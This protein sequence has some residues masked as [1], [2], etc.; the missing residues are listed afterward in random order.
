MNKI[1]IISA[2]LV[3]VVFLFFSNRSLNGIINYYIPMYLF[4]VIGLLIILSTLIPLK[5]INIAN[6]IKNK[7]VLLLFFILLIS[8]TLRIWYLG[9]ESLWV[10]EIW[11]AY[12]SLSAINEKSFLK[13]FEIYD[14]TKIVTLITYISGS[15][16]GFTSE[17]FLRLPFAL[18]G[19][20]SVFISY[21]LGK[22]FADNRVGMIYAWISCLSPVFIMQSRNIR[23]Y[24][25][26]Q[27]SVTLLLYLYLK[28]INT[29]NI[30]MLIA[31][32]FIAVISSFLVP[33]YFLIIIP[34]LFLHYLVLN[35]KALKV[36][37]KYKKTFAVFIFV[38]VSLIAYIFFKQ[39]SWILNE[40]FVHS[41]FYYFKNIFIYEFIFLSI[42][43]LGLIKG[44]KKTWFLYLTIFFTL[45]I[46]SFSPLQYP[47]YYFFLLP[48]LY[49]LSA[50]A[51]DNFYIKMKITHKYLGVFCMLLIAMLPI[52]NFSKFNVYNSNV[53]LD[54]KISLLK[55]PNN[56]EAIFKYFNY[57]F[58]EL[59]HDPLL[60]KPDYK[61]SIQFIRED[62]QTSNAIIIAESPQSLK[63]YNKVLGLNNQLIHPYY[64]FK[65]I[66][67]S[68][69][70]SNKPIYAVVGH[71]IKQDERNMVDDQTKD[72]IFNKMKLIKK[73]NALEVY[74]L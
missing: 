39:F 13:A 31:F 32:L 63:Y 73:F 59:F 53:L 27:I 8:L 70:N 51:L 58:Y 69:A 2:T 4:Y 68:I 14:K 64:S 7:S 37:L 43:I 54:K 17:F 40:T 52:Y 72:F 67:A 11:H 35:R 60:I 1:K 28:F 3:T 19:V 26:M 56:S 21:F 36:K 25:I 38:F 15:L 29:K 6:K 71:R 30:K 9:R 55:N 46:L 57:E 22:E 18:L 10:D 45:I 50:F 48:I 24:I 5:K 41:Y 33:F 47:K 34:F 66:S 44:I 62:S 12:A 65:D 42:A 74:K 16:F 23:F 20:L 49:L 61:N